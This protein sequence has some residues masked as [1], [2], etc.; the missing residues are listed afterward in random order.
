[1]GMIRQVTSI[2]FADATHRRTIICH[3]SSKRKIVAGVIA[4]MSC[5]GNSAFLMGFDSPKYE[6]SDIAVYG[7]LLFPREGHEQKAHLLRSTDYP[8]ESDSDVEEGRV[9]TS[10]SWD[11]K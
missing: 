3:A 7:R 9:R 11:R 10:W 6:S 8:E 4:E 1:M 2:A 5:A